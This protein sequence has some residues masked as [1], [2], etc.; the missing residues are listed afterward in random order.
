MHYKI[1]SH[2]SQLQLQSGKEGF[3]SISAASFNKRGDKIYTGD[4][5]G[6]IT[7][8]DTDTL[9]VSPPS[10]QLSVAAHNLLGSQDS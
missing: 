9:E 4:A 7:I 2:L 10:F 1:K 5:K 6:V 3:S 8:I